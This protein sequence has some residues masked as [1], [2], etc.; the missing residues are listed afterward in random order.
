MIGLQ[1]VVRCQSLR[2]MQAIKAQ[3]CLTPSSFSTTW[4][5]SESL[6]TADLKWSRKHLQGTEETHPC[7]SGQ[8]IQLPEHQ[9]GKSIFCACRG[10]KKNSF[11]RQ[12]KWCSSELLTKG[13]V[14][15]MRTAKGTFV[16][17]TNTSVMKK[18]NQMHHRLHIP[19]T[20]LIYFMLSVL[21]YVVLNT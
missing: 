20:Q 21:Y 14:E 7:F 18:L 16:H 17:H 3:E 9:P 4:V 1:P 10:F 5:C 6:G 11:A 19:N 12:L 8:K 13:V 15:W 2:A